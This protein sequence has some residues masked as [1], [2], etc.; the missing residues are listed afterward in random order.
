MNVT[1][2][3]LTNCH[4]FRVKYAKFNFGWGFTPDPADKKTYSA[5]L[6]FLTGLGKGNG[7]GRRRIG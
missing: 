4:I 5:S 2:I 6:D 7:K 1:E 3:M